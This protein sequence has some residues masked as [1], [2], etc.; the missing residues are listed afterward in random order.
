M[1]LPSRERAF[2]DKRKLVEYCLV[3]S[4]WSFSRVFNGGVSTA[5]PAALEPLVRPDVHR[6]P[7]VTLRS[8]AP[9]G[10]FSRT[11][12]LQFRIT[13]KPLM[14]SEMRRQTPKFCV[15][16]FIRVSRS[17]R[18]LAGVNRNL[19]LRPPPKLTT[20]GPNAISKLFVFSC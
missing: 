6:R 3:A 7:Q 18:G 16:L 1:K 17:I 9:V 12:L 2:F 19:Q 14:L 8:A 15:W 13:T 11:L 10:V 20:R 5:E 4:T